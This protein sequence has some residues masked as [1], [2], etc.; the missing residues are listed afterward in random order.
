MATWTN[1]N[2]PVLTPAGA[3]TTNAVTETTDQFAAE[4][5]AK[6]LVR[7]NNASA[8][9]AEVR[10]QD[11]NTPAPLGRAFAAAYAVAGNVPA[12]QARTFLVDAA[13]FRQSDG[14][15]VFE[16]SA[17]MTNAASLAEVYRLP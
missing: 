11:P 4:F 1:I 15:I 10:I 5:G 12:G 3:P 2:T 9:P 7:I 6:Y 16:Y 13:R 8:T 14:N 17:D